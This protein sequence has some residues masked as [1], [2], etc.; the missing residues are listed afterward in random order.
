MLNKILDKA[1]ID[2][3]L[4]AKNYLFAE[5]I[6]KSVGLL[7]LPILTQLLEPSDYGS[8]KIYE[9]A[10]SFFVPLSGLALPVAIKRY[11]YDKTDDYKIYAGTN[12]NFIII[13]NTVLFVIVFLCR[14]LIADFIRLK[15][16][17]VI[18]AFI[19][20]FLMIFVKIYFD[21]LEANKF[22]KQF[23]ISKI[24]RGILIT[25]FSLLWIY[26][27]KENKYTGRIYSD[28]LIT[29]TFVI[30]IILFIKKNIY[31]FS[32]KI[33]QLKSALKFSLPIIPGIL[34]AF[35]LTYFD[36]IIIN[37]I[38]GSH[39]T[40]LYSM[41]YQIGMIIHMINISSISAYQPIF[42]EALWKN[43][44]DSLK[45]IMSN[46][47]KFIY[48]CASGLILFSYEIGI[49]LSSESY[50]EGLF[51]IPVIVLSYTMLFLYTI[52]LNYIYYARKTIF[53]SLAVV[54]TIGINIILNYWL[55]PIYGY[56]VAAFTTLFAYSIQF[57]FFWILALIITKD[58]K[59]I[60]PIKIIIRYIF[61]VFLALA[62]FYGVFYFS[63]NFIL[64]IIIKISAMLIIIYLLFKKTI[65]IL[66]KNERK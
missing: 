44:I 20:A 52:Y 17:V 2:F 64:G 57:L 12:I 36:A 50:H 22:S 62:I 49:V 58:K 55:I 7:T 26:L 45:L 65:L 61:V 24:I 63:D 35:A 18:L 37:Q 4:N 23:S 6:I 13:Y 9:S 56:T 8:L 15:S 28:I 11:F 60:L 40:G 16:F 19:M 42:Y 10:V 43:N 31:S 14:D 27:L 3:F 5:L 29:G 21:F 33:E 53:S 32:F 1:N 48:F 51:I 66:L 34:S 30:F 54:A 41:A 39:K 25:I 59:T 38:E 46:Y 47:S